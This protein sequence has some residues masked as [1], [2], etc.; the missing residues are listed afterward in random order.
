MKP[1]WDIHLI[2]NSEEETAFMAGMCDAHTH[3]LD[4]YGSLEIQFVLAYPTPM[5]GHIL[6][7]IGARVANG[8]R[9]SDG[10]LLK[11]ICDDEAELKVYETTDVFGEP[12]LR[13]IMPDGEFKY[14]EESTE[15]PYNMQ[16]EN[17]Y[18][19]VEN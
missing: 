7:E 3:G 1:T 12:I 15:Y 6:N 11:G 17:P 9:L 19:G 8:E 4:K 10:S 18:I 16:Y 14:P 5:I 13:I 2:T